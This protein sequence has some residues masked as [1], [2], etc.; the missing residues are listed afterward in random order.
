MAIITIMVTIDCGRQPSPVR[1]HD[2]SPLHPALRHTVYYV[3]THIVQILRPHQTL[4]PIDA[5]GWNYNNW[6][7]C[8]LHHEVQRLWW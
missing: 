7:F 5:I 1:T 6:T 2:S 8:H 4:E 3:D